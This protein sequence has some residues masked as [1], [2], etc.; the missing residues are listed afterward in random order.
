MRKMKLQPILNKNSPWAHM[1]LEF[2]VLGVARKL[3]K[4]VVQSSKRK[5]I[6][7]EIFFF[8]HGAQTTYD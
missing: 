2:D 4:F 3:V 7:K 8:S 1:E 5:E 6:E